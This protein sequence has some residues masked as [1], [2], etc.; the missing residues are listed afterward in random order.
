MKIQKKYL[1]EKAKGTLI[2]ESARYI[3]TMSGGIV[4]KIQGTFK[5]DTKE[6]YKI[7][8][9]KLAELIKEEQLKSKT[10]D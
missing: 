1:K 8:K 6:L 10:N 5:G 4:Q 2:W 7:Y 3:P 9:E